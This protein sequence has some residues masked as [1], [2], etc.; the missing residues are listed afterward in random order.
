MDQIRQYLLSILAASI[1]CAIAI[2]LSD[3]QKFTSAIIKLTTALLLSTTVIAP[4]V[5]LRIDDVSSYFGDLQVNAD[6][7]IAIG[8]NGALNETAEI[9]SQ[10]VEAYILDKAASYGVEISVCAKISD[11]TTMIPDKVI[12]EGSA[13]PY[14]K[15]RLQQVIAEDLGIPKENQTWN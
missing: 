7:M 4:L 10:R 5:T 9:I 8:E 3:N 12:L 2:K 15:Q 11:P 14:I 1:I 6:E 13:S